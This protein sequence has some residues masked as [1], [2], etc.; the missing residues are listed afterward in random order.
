MRAVFDRVMRDVGGV[1]AAR[2]AIAEPTSRSDLLAKVDPPLQ[3][4]DP[5]DGYFEGVAAAEICRGAGSVVLPLPIEAMLLRRPSGRPLALLS[6]HG[7]LEHGDLFSE[8][9]VS[10]GAGQT[11]VVT[12]GPDLI[13]S[14]VG[15]FVNKIPPVRVGE[16]EPIT[17]FEHAMLHVL[18]SWYV[19]GALE[20]ALDL[21]TV[22]ATERVAFG[23]PIA[24]YQGV[25]FPLAD[26]CSELQALYGWRCTVSTACTSR[27]SRRS[28]TP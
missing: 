26:A 10:S 27:L 20:K 14:K 8:W 7:R 9:D 2:R 15:P 23:A 5:R 21:A 25:A 19:F 28:R 24:A 17:S 4:L 22:Y 11:E 1:D 18:S 16:G 13:G 12:S 3:S 6:A